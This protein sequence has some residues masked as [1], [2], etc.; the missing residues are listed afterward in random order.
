MDNMD[1]MNNMEYFND[2][3]NYNTDSDSDFEEEY[4]EADEASK[5]RFNLVICELYNRGIHGVPDIHSGVDS[6][7]LVN[8]RFKNFDLCD[9]NDY[10]YIVMLRARYM[11]LSN[12]Y[13]NSN[14]K[15]VNRTRFRNYLNIITRENYI[16]PEIAECIYLSG[17][18]CVAIIKTFWIRLIQR[19]W[20]KVYKA[21][22]ETIR[23]MR[24]VS[25]LKNREINTK[26]MLSMPSLKGMLSYL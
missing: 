23:K 18:E 25:Y 7:Y 26:S 11:N 14:N 24:S 4:Y 12:K 15:C 10:D 20:K 2:E 3:N 9:I 16:R 13:I 6:H 8:S 5:T 1:N 21:K 22:M 19:T 17:N